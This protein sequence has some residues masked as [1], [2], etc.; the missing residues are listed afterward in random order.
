MF[1][2]G[3]E[4]IEEMGKESEMGKD[5]NNVNEGRSVLIREESTKDMGKESEMG[6]KSTKKIRE[7]DLFF[8][9]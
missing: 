8:N 9:G 3:R 6:K 2:I 1:L 4:S 5:V 7:R